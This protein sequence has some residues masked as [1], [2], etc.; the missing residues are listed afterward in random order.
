MKDAIP[1]PRWW[2]SLIQKAAAT[3]FGSWLLAGNLHRIDRPFLRLSSGRTSLTGIL[4]GL[5][6]VILTTTGAK[7]GKPRSTPLAAVFDEDKV[8]LIASYLGKCRHP[9]WY[10][11]LKANPKARLKIAGEERGYIAREAQG[12]ERERYWAQAVQLYHGY[13]NYREK[14]SNRRIPVMVL[15]LEK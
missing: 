6:V 1:K 11:N 15:T 12:E 10:H 4:A 2:H 8:I 3:S 14:A 5:P 7:S 9:A 13:E